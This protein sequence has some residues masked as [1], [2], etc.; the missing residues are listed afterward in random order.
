MMVELLIFSCLK[1]PWLPQEWGVIF[2]PAPTSTVYTN[3][4][5]VEYYFK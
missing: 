2:I 4:T 3:F 5:P 1:S